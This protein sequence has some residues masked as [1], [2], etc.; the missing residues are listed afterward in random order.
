L[1]KDGRMKH[2]LIKYRLTN[3]EREAWHRDI[4]AFIDAI[5]NDPALNGRISYRCMKSRDGADYYHLAAAADDQAIKALQSS[6]FF[7]RYNE[8]TRRV[9]GGEVEVLPLEIVAETR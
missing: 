1:E 5:Q 7:K 3:G 4:A 8:Q 2:F 6:D 9:A